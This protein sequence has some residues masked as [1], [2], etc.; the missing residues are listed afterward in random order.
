M[1]GILSDA[2]KRNNTQINQEMIDGDNGYEGQDK[3]HNRIIESMEY[4]GLGEANNDML[5]S[6]PKVRI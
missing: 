2:R 4:Q 1:K 3:S 6:S 5:F